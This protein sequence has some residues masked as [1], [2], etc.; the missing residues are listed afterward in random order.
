MPTPLP[1]PAVPTAD[2]H[3]VSTADDLA[4]STAD[5]HAVS[6][7]DDRTDST[8]NQSTSLRRLHAQQTARDRST[9]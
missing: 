1:T 4:D 6:T 8:D 7:A 3:A 2:G 9:W 5:D